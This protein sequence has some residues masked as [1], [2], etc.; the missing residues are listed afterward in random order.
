MGQLDFL[1]DNRASPGLGVV[2]E[3]YG[4][5]S[6]IF[7]MLQ[8]FDLGPYF[9]CG[10]SKEAVGLFRQDPR[11]S[12]VSGNILCDL[13]DNMIVGTGGASPFLEE[14]LRIANE[15]CI[16]TYALFDHYT[17]YSNRVASCDDSG[18]PDFFIVRDDHAAGLV[19]EVF[20]ISSDKII[21][22]ESDKVTYITSAVRKARKN[23]EPSIFTCLVVTEALL[24]V[25]GVVEP[26][27]ELA[28]VE[29]LIDEAQRLFGKKSKI[30]IRKHPKEDWAKYSNL[31][32]KEKSDVSVEFDFTADIAEALLD[33]DV[34]VG[35]KSSVLELSLKSGISTYSL[36]T[37]SLLRRC[38][39]PSVCDRIRILEC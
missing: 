38:L 19:M 34:V 28:K 25:D 2:I 17:D 37:G 11:A 21:V 33:V 39:P 23:R 30:L 12:F 8:G 1:S 18:F 29:W 13:V 26:N 16:T 20:D 15:R 7:Y 24:P 14:M 35:F 31:K 32:L 3:D 6:E 5:A 4:S 36:L 27:Y 10:E 22:R 9:V